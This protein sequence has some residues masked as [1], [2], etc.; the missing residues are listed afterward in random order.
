MR[1]AL[2]HNE[3][4]L[5]I[6]IT[7][8]AGCLPCSDLT[9]VQLHIG[10]IPEHSDVLPL[11]RSNMPTLFFSNSQRD[12][13]FLHFNPCLLPYR[14][15][16]AFDKQRVNETIAYS[17]AK[18]VEIHKIS[19]KRVFVQSVSFPIKQTAVRRMHSNKF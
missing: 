4:D 12:D 11:I 5:R 16:N 15:P 10:V 19:I 13:Y 9:K 3:C 1:N 18:S 17:H 6:I 14:N 8:P 7:S 2:V